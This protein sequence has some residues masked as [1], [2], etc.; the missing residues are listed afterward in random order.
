MKEVFPH[1]YQEVCDPTLV[2]QETETYKPVSNKLL[3]DSVKRAIQDQGF[4]I[5]DENYRMNR[6]KQ[7]LFATFSTESN[8][9]GYSTN[10]G[11]VNS[12]NKVRAVGVATGARVQRC[13]NLSFS[14]YKK[15][16]KH[17]K[18]VYTDLGPMIN[19]MVSHMEDGVEEILDRHND[20]RKRSID[21]IEAS[22]LLGEM[23]Y[24]DLIGVTQMNTVM[25]SIKSGDYVFGLD[26]YF[27]FNMHV[28][29]ALKSSH[30]T[31]IIED[32]IGVENW[33]LNK[34]RMN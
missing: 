22:H 15:L 9:V 28:T 11:I 26:N 30:P 18:N 23:L 6:N 4:T 24:E 3:I 33:V 27:D 10:V 32:H 2:P 20:M 12:Y 5:D 7:Q 1:S 13:S 34:A 29:E 25:K 14:E 19:N 21:Q 17:T 31:H 16:R 8:V